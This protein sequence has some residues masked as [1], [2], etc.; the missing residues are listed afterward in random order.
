MWI[1]YLLIGIA[2]AFVLW[3]I[4]AGIK[5]SKKLEKK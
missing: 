1:S 3:I 4:I 2:G 5:E